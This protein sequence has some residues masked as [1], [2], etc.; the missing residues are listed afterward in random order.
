MYSRPAS[1][2]SIR[3][4]GRTRR[5]SVSSVSR[6]IQPNIQPSPAPVLGRDTIQV[7]MAIE[8]DVGDD[9][10]FKTFTMSLGPGSFE[11]AVA[12]ARQMSASERKTLLLAL[13]SVEYKQISYEDLLRT[14]RFDA[15]ESTHRPVSG[16]T[17]QESASARRMASARNMSAAVGTFI[18]RRRTTYSHLNITLKRESL[19]T[20]QT[21]TCGVPSHRLRRSSCRHW[22]S[23]G[24]VRAAQQVD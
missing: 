7:G 24:T 16:S 10:E 1:G 15:H 22:A 14:V 5:Q 12:V 11:H 2:S 8:E 6:A 21:A 3:A 9:V 17:Q 4:A 18:R 20:R 23:A 19:P 13:H